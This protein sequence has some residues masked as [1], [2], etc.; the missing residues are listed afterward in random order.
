MLSNGNGG[1]DVS[2]IPLV[3]AWLGLED[4]DLLMCDLMT[5]KLHKPDKQND[6]NS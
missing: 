2:G 3:M 5:I 1:F 4:L 6:G